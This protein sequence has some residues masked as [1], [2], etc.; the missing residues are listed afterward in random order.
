ML[1]MAVLFLWAPISCGRG[2][3]SFCLACLLVIFLTV[4]DGLRGCRD[5]VSC[6]RQHVQREATIAAALEIGKQNVTANAV[7]PQTQWSGFW[8]V[9]DLTDDPETWPNHAMAVY[10]GLDALVAE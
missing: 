8:G 10:Y 9:R 4:P 1:M 5:I 3:H 6:H 2:F 7:I